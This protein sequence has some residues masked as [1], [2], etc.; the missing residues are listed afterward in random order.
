MKIQLTLLLIFATTVVHGQSKTFY[1]KYVDLYRGK[2]VIFSSEYEALPSLAVRKP[3]LLMEV[4][5]PKKKAKSVDTLLRIYPDTIKGD[6]LVFDEVSV[7]PSVDQYVGGTRY[8]LPLRSLKNNKRYYLDYNPASIYDFPFTVVEPL[9]VTEGFFCTE[10]RS[11]SDEFTSTHSVSSPM[12][13]DVVF[14]RKVKDGRTYFLM[15]LKASSSSLTAMGKTGAIVLFNDG[16][17][18]EFKEAEMDVLRTSLAGHYNILTTVI[19]DRSMIEKLT[20]KQIKGFRLYMDD[21]MLT[22]FESLRYMDLI[23]CITKELNR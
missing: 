15:S 18:I 16:D 20:M 4:V 1:G 12:G 7:R 17:K 6:T 10:L 21:K 5:A 23:K 13:D 9:K 22:N 14:T 3:K 8:L 11:E 2:K 19:L